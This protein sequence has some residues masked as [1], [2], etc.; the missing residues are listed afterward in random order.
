VIA[1]DWWWDTFGDNA[2]PPEDSDT[3]MVQPKQADKSKCICPA[4]GLSAGT[5][6]PD[7][8]VHKDWYDKHGREVRRKLL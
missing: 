8:P 7:C 2:E 6:D 5:F 4:L 3:P 1:P